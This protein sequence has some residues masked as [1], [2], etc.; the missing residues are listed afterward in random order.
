MNDLKP[1]PFCGGSAILFKVKRNKGYV[2]CVEC[3]TRT[4]TIH[5]DTD[6]ELNWKQ[7]AKNIWNRRI[8]NENG[9]MA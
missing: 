9:N 7:V 3:Q 8:N 4:T 5:N 6:K 1:C 2:C